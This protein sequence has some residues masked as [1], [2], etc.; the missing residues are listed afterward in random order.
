MGVVY[1]EIEVGSS[2]CEAIT[3]ITESQLLLYSMLCVCVFV[4][5]S[6]QSQCQFSQ[7]VD[8]W[9]LYLLFIIDTACIVCGK[10]YVAV[11]CPSYVCL[12]VPSIDR[13]KP[14]AAAWRSAVNAGSAVLT[15]DVGSWT[16][17]CR[18]WNGVFC[19][20]VI[21]AHTV[22]VHKRNYHHRVCDTW[23]RCLWLSAVNCLSAQTYS[24]SI[25]VWSFSR[26]FASA[27]LSIYSIRTNRACGWLP[28]CLC[29]HDTFHCWH[30]P[31]SKWS[32][33]Y[34]TVGCPSVRPSRH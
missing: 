1:C 10:I 3:L 27:Q 9:S 33:V 25:R 24:T 31:H 11:R 14:T 22:T 28:L 6:W 26:G 34:V 16:Q 20:R 13:C 7:R 21:C 8:S 32:R 19:A 2:R 23:R 30:C 4:C 12:F 15:A 5:R 17:T 29:G 18:I